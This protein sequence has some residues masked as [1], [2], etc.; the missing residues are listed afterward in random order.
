MCVAG[1][2]RVG[3]GIGPGILRRMPLPSLRAITPLVLFAACRGGPVAASTAAAMTRA[4]NTVMPD[5]DDLGYGD[6]GHWNAD[7]KIP[8]PHLDRF[9]TVGLRCV[10]AHSPSGI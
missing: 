2:L 3:P 4:P 8:M 6:F 7:A 1:E 5:A 10:D 9:A